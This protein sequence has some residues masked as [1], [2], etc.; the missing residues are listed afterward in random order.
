MIR[1]S[2][3]LFYAV[4]LSLLL[5]LASPLISDAGSET[6]EMDSAVA[7]L[8]ALRA[9]A[10]QQ[11]EGAQAMT[12]D[13]ENASVRD[14]L[15]LR[16]KAMEIRLAGAESTFQ[17]TDLV[18]KLEK[19]GHDVADAR[20]ELETRLAQAGVI[21]HSLYAAE[22]TRRHEL[23]EE[24]EVALAGGSEP[25]QELRRLSRG[26]DA[27]IGRILAG[28]AGI[29]ASLA[30]LGHS[31]EA[32]N[33]WLRVRVAKR[34]RLL[35]SRM[36]LLSAQIADASARSR[37]QPDDAALA[38][39]IS[40][41][42]ARLEVSTTE[43]EQVIR[44]MSDLDM[45]TAGYKQAL[46]EYTGEITSDVFDRGVA[47]QLLAR[48]FKSVQEAL[49]EKGPG[50]VF[51]TLVF[52]VILAFF[53][54]MARF[55]RKVAQRAVSAPHLRFS[56]LLKR[57]VVSSSHGAVILLGLLVA[58]SQLGIEVGPMLAGLGIVGFIVGFALQETL[59]NFASGIM[60]LLYRP[61]DVGD[62]VNCA[63]G[64]F[65]TVSHMSLV[66]TTVLTLDNQTLI[67]PNGKIWGDVITNVA[68]QRI[69]RV[70]LV[71]GI[72][73][74]DDIPFAEKVLEGIL[75]EHPKV[76]KD[77]EAM[78]KVHELGDSS[79]NL[80]VRPWV[81]RDDY[82]DVYWDVTREVKLRFDREGI[83]IPFPQ[84]DIHVMSGDT[85]AAEITAPMVV[86]ESQLSSADGPGADE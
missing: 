37:V 26:S 77:P 73:Y 43:L 22:Q 78:V 39:I 11:A 23:D 65:G 20:K 6:E 25:G 12:A 31:A 48:W 64:V 49:V 44:I 5:P 55:V 70:D 1:A 27:L 80:V 66:S 36:E 69:R 17:M 51:K 54:G 21:V 72:S 3:S 76:L 83:S 59:G 38:G 46:I 68:A 50:A 4:V 19:G 41:K 47:G 40:I 56:Q 33:E 63:G 15:A 67:V 75:A 71:V 2:Q 35:W 79:V 7:G 45:D 14:A 86:G 34:A 16:R 29:A 28:G 62:L 30:K 85:S 58:L 32:E 42:M 57:M 18:L 74:G 60:I 82:W 53:W 24:I 13:A 61:F 10:T 52:A 9:K 84:R 8:E 81:A